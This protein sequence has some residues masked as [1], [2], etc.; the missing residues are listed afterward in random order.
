MTIGPTG[1]TMIE[2]VSFREVIEFGHLGDDDYHNIIITDRED[3]ETEKRIELHLHTK[4]SAQD[5]V[6][7]VRAYMDTATKFGMKAMAIT[8]HGCVNAL[9]D[10]YEYLNDKK[11]PRK[12]QEFKLIYGVEGYLVDDFENYYVNE[13]NEFS[14]RSHDLNGSYVIFEFATTGMNKKNDDIILI[15]AVRINN[16]TVVDSFK[17]YIYTN[18]PINI[19]IRDNTGVKE[20][21]LINAGNLVSALENLM[22]FAAGSVLVTSNFNSI[23]SSLALLSISL[24]L[25]R[26]SFISSTY[27]ATASLISIGT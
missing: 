21:D 22:K 17:K 19:N 2:E 6:G 14:N 16:F 7:E 3:N 13:N 24:A 15:E 26:R 4:S 23:P 11:R 9:A 25:L 8:D 10:A 18:K 1:I 27:F 5:G 20:S 12:N